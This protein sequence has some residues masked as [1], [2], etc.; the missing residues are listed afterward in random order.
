MSWGGL[1]NATGRNK[2]SSVPALYRLTWEAVA[3]ASSRPSADITER[4]ISIGT[5]IGGRIQAPESASRT[6]TTLD[7]TSIAMRRRSR[8]RT[9][10]RHASARFMAPN[11]RSEIK[12]L[13]PRS[14][15]RTLGS[16][17]RVSKRRSFSPHKKQWVRGAG[18]AN[19]SSSFP[20]PASQS[21]AVPPDVTVARRSPTWLKSKATAGVSFVS[22]GTS[23]RGKLQEE[24]RERSLE[25]A[26]PSL[27]LTRRK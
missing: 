25:E 15:K 3:S 6:C 21:R 12:R 4:K 26:G 11:S 17:E 14:H 5:A 18:W 9:T 23:N 20:E 13:V 22:G 10:L 27:G 8:V 24:S 2:G 7:C 19:S 1:D 16:V